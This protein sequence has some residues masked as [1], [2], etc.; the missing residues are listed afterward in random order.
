MRLIFIQ[1]RCRLPAE[2]GN[3]LDGGLFDQALFAVGVGG[4]AQ[5]L[6]STHWLGKTIA[7]QIIHPPIH[8]VDKTRDSP[9][10]GFA[11]PPDDLLYFMFHLIDGQAPGKMGNPGALGRCG[12]QSTQQ[13]PKIHVGFGRIEAPVDEM[14]QFEIRFTK[15]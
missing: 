10:F 14:A 3:E 8:P 11:A 13:H 4:I 7:K 1:H 6:S 15:L 12:E 9:R 5:F 2:R